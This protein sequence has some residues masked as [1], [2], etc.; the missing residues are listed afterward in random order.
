[1]GPDVEY[2]RP[3]PSLMAQRPPLSAGF[4]GWGLPRPPLFRFCTLRL[5]C[6]DWPDEGD[7]VWQIIGLHDMDGEFETLELRQVMPGAPNGTVGGIIKVWRRAHEDGY[8]RVWRR[9]LEDPALM[10]SNA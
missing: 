5:R 3:E 8:L 4:D 2:P 7:G 6:K 9:D 1:M 10:S